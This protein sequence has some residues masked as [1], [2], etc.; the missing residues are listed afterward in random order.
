[1]RTLPLAGRLLAQGALDALPPLSCDM[2]RAPPLDAYRADARN[3]VL[4]KH[5]P[6]G[7]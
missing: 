7:P 3:P 6:L 5:R 2:G 4:Q 1:M